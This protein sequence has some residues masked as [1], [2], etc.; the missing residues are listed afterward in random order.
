VSYFKLIPGWAGSQ[1]N[2][3]SYDIWSEDQVQ[4]AKNE[5]VINEV[6]AKRLGVL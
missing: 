2:S 6:C 4:T 3:I 5:A 1:Q